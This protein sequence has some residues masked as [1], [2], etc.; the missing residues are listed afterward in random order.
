MFPQQLFTEHIL[1]VFL[2]PLF[3]KNECN[4]FEENFT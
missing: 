3:H 1:Q 2:V 4:H